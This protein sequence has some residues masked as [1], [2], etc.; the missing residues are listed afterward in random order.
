[1]IQAVDAAMTGAPGPPEQELA[2]AW[3]QAIELT[4][5]LRAL[6]AM[7]TRLKNVAQPQLEPADAA[8]RARLDQYLDTALLTIALERTEL[9]QSLVGQQSSL[10]EAYDR[11]RILAATIREIGAPLIPLLPEV[12]LIPLIGTIDTARSSRSKRRCTGLTA[13]EP[14]RCCWT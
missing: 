14:P 4:T 10:R 1:L 6:H 3:Q 11:E 13:I 5:D 12:L 8:A 2:D 7:I 9:L